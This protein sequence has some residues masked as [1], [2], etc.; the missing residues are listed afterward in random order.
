MLQPCNPTFTQARDA[1][2]QAE[3]NYY[4]GVYR[5]QVWRAFAKRGLGA[6]SVQSGWIN[7]FNVPKYCAAPFVASLNPLSS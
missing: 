1:I 6:D 5:C 7:G 3:L 4:G 2:L